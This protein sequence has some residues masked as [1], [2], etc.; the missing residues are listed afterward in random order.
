MSPTFKDVSLEVSRG[1]D[2]AEVLKRLRLLRDSFG[3]ISGLD[4]AE[5]VRKDRDRDEKG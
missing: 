3:P 5:V 4:S 2:P 1:I